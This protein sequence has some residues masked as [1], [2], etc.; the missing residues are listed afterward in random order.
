MPIS[1]IRIWRALAGRDELAAGGRRGR[2]RRTRTVRP[3]STGMPAASSAP[4]ATIRMISV[5]GI[6]RQLGLAGSRTRAC[7][8]TPCPTDASPNSSTRRSGARSRSWRWR[9]RSA[10]PS[11]R[12]RRR[13]PRISNSISAERPSAASAPARGSPGDVGELAE[14]S[15]SRR[16][17]RPRG[18]LSESGPLRV[19]TN[20]ILGAGWSLKSGGVDRHPRGA[21]GVAGAALRTSSISWRCRRRCRRRSRSPRTRPSRGSRATGACRSSDPCGARG[22]TV[23]SLDVPSEVPSVRG[24]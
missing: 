14:L 11:M 2:S 22:W 1:I 23:S 17:R 19:W 10:R 13:R 3:S 15:S 9:P 20:T 12:R 16:R 6:D 21:A 24:R 8:R 7:R 4:N 5:I 18:A